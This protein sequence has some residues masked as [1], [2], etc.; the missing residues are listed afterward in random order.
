[1]DLPT[2]FCLHK[3]W[4]ELYR[5][6][7]M[8]IRPKPETASNEVEPAYAKDD[9]GNDLVG[10][11]MEVIPPVFLTIKITGKKEERVEWGKEPIGIRQ[12]LAA[13][14]SK[15][16]DPRYNFIC[17]PGD[18]K[19]DIDGKVKKDLDALLESW[20]GNTKPVT[21]LDLSGIPSTILNDIIGAVLR[22]LY[23]ALK[24]RTHI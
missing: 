23:D 17:N 5:K 13:L 22:I 1:V 2:P 18:W 15:L 6:D 11:A 21:I 19:P 8:T 24:K 20:I 14:G 12:Q 7:F 3:L 4:I 10:S 9:N 16:K